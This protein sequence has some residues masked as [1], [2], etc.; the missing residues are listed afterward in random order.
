VVVVVVVG[1][2]RTPNCISADSNLFL[3]AGGDV[4]IYD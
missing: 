1:G 4:D 3:G 2:G